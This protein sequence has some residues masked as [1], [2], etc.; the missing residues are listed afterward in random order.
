MHAAGHQHSFQFGRL[1]H[2][3][4]I[5]LR[6]AEAHH[7]LDAGA[8]VPRTVEKHHFARSGQVLDI[9]LEIPLSA[10][11]FGRF[12]QCHHACAARIQM[13]HIALNR[14]ALACRIASFKQ[15]HN[16]L[17]AF[18]HPALHFQKL[19]LQLFLF[20][21]VH[22]AA[23]ARFIRIIRRQR[24]GIAV[25]LADLA[26]VFQHH[27]LKDF[28]A[29]LLVAQFYFFKRL[30]LLLAHNVSSGWLNLANKNR[31]VLSVVV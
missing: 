24:R 3:Q 26:L 6:V 21:F 30:E 23:H 31:Y 2:K 29:A 14:A 7:A 1:A 9:A 13:L 10:F 25:F 5:F 16:A 12:F 20:F 27:F 19:D 28:E 15:A 18:F 22:A 4:Q 17:A 8:V 11:G